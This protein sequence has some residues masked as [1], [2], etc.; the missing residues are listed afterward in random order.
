MSSVGEVKRIK[1]K[2]AM[3]LKEAQASRGIK[4]PYDWVLESKKLQ[5]G[6]SFVFHPQRESYW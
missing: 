2:E 5:D 4:I 6:D 1:Q 3:N